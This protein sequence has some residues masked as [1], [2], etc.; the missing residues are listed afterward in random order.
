MVDRRSEGPDDGERIHLLPEQVRGIDVRPDDRADGVAHAARASARCRR[1]AADAAR[2]RC[3]SMPAPAGVRAEVLPQLD[4]RGP[5]AVQQRQR[6]AGPRIPDEIDRGR[7][8]H[9][10]GCRTSTT[11]LRT[12]SSAASR[13]VERISATCSSPT[14]G[15]SGQAE[16][17]SAA[18]RRPRLSN[19]AAN[20]ARRRASPSS[21]S[22][23]RCGAEDWPP[24]AISIPVAPISR[25]EVE[26]ASNP[27]SGE[28]VGVEAELQRRGLT[29]PARR[30]A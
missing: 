15:W 24:V 23:R 28:R 9:R 12:P 14:T 30:R 29:K 11:I 8:G 25:G 19:A 2:G 18:M 22:I 6:V 27:R 5:L 20:S 17:L 10:P 7:P 3:R 4:R 16:Q 26:A 13:I 1:G 21:S